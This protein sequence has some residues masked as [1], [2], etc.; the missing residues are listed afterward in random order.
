VDIPL[1]ADE[2]PECVV[3]LSGADGL[4]VWLGDF[5]AEEFG[6]AI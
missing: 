5:A 3:G 2:L 1:D 6:H 4:T